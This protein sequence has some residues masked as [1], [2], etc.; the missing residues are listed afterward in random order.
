MSSLI[1]AGVSI[2][3]LAL[4]YIFYS[5]KV[6]QWIGLDDN[7]I[8]PSVAMN[9]GVDYV[10]AKHW[11]IL[12]GHH[13]AS[14]AGA[15]PII[16]PVI[17]C[18]YW[19]WLPAVIWIVVGGIFIGAVHDFI[20]LVMS[21]RNQGKSITTVTE[22]VMGKT[23]KILFSVFAFLSL[24]LV[25]AVFAAVAGK[26]LATTPAVV[27]P[28]FGL[29]VV[30]LIVGFL[31]YRM[32]LPVLLCS[33]MGLL[34]LI[35]LI[36]AGYYIPVELGVKNAAAWWTVILLIYGMIASVTPVTMLLQPRDHLAGAVLYLGLL[37][38]FLGLIVTHP[39][40]KSPGVI[41]FSS[42][43]EGWMWPMLLVSI[44]C[45]AIS[46]FHSLVASGTTSKQLPRMRDARVIGYGAMIM[47]SALAVL[48]VMAVSA[49]LYWKSAPA[50]M[51]GLVYQEV[52]KEGGWIKAFGEGYGQLTKVFFGGLGTLVG[53]TMLKTF[54]MT[55]LD[56][57]TRISRYLCNELLGETFGIRIMK[58]KYVAVLLVGVLAGALALGNWKAIW[59]IFG[60][61]NQLIASLV[62]IVASLYLL[63][64]NRRFMFTAVPAVIMLV[65]TIGALVYKTY[66]FVTAEKANI[67]LA[68]VAVILII[69]AIFLALM[70]LVSAIRAR[71][72]IADKQAGENKQAG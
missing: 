41:S 31:I 60:A 16:G 11:T 35:G 38:G 7:E 15:A 24:I 36:V 2:L 12:F 32:Q 23:S 46:G 33:V 53:I 57:A 27:I 54:I 63:T 71:A 42:P 25:V 26:T 20:A 64:R 58:N 13:F 10:P 5:K 52:F 69:L 49:G 70:A 65:T 9:D 21:L 66:S 51:E 55:S 72:A 14:I 3:L 17:A 6:K 34:L 1:V 39:N 4:G 40:M 50:G 59:P 45:G 68:T 29:I 37:F 62:L 43:E 22:S 47:E 18:L 67:M 44:A 19:G 56:T 8:P 28:T 61:S 30:A 48:A